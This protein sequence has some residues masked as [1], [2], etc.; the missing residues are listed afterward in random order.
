MNMTAARAIS[1]PP[2]CPKLFSP[3]SLWADLATAQARAGRGRDRLE[4]T[5]SEGEVE[6]YN[7][8]A[9]LPGTGKTDEVVIIGGHIDSWDLGTGATDNGTGTIAVL[10]AARP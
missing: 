1:H 8:V 3:P 5:F 7:T 10:E 9:E 2:N 4:N 6:V